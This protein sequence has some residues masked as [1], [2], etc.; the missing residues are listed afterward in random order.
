MGRVAGAFADTPFWMKY[1]MN[2]K[3]E[4][5]KKHCRENGVCQYC[6][7]KFKGLF[8]QSCAKCGKAKDY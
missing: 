4:N 7:S 8:K 3:T 6:G 2:R 1:C 5:W